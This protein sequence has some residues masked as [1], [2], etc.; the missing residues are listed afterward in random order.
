M[1]KRKTKINSKHKLSN[2]ID[3]TLVQRYFNWESIKHK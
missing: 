3:G 1:N 2:D